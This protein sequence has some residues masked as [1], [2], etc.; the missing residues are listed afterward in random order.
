M[1][2]R[3]FLRGARDTPAAEPMTHPKSEPLLE[4]I[5]VIPLPS[6]WMEFNVISCLGGREC[7]GEERVAE[8]GREEGRWR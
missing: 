4:V 2:T 7:A 8:Y 1:C 3:V 5:L 6:G